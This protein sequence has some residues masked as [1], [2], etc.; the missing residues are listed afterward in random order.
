MEHIYFVN[1]HPDDLL[2]VIG[3]A[4]KLKATGKYELHVIDVSHGEN[5]L[6][7]IA[8]PEECS[9]LREAEESEVCAILGT[10]PT[11]LY[12]RDG[13]AF[14]S[15]K[16]CRALA[17]MY[18]AAPPRA[19][20]T[21]WP[22]DRHLDHM[23]C[24]SIALNALRLASGNSRGVMKQGWPEVFFY[25]CRNSMACDPGC[26]VPLTEAEMAEKC[27]IISLYRCQQGPRLAE[28]EKIRNAHF[29]TR[30]RLP[31]A[32]ALTRL[33]PLSPEVRSVLDGIAWF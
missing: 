33:Q 9:K 27:S 13:S 17:A 7:G 12:E 32:E 22:L 11:W 26:L 2:A 21:Q 1:A 31:Y 23:M 20:F 10:A 24:A 8:S 30:A 14:A 15:E 18:A 5:G 4:L 6:T 28:D 16:S 19:I 29:G 25:H 3:T